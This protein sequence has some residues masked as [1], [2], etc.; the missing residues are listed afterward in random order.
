[1]SESNTDLLAFCVALTSPLQPIYDLVRE[2]DDQK[3][4]TILL[5]PQNVPAQFLPYLAQWVGAILTPGMGE[6]QRRLEI[7]QPTSW[8]RGQDPSIEL[9]TKRELTGEKWVRIRQ[10]TPAPGHTYIRTLL[11][12]TANPDRVK[13][14][15]EEHGV[16][17]WQKLDYEAIAGVSYADIAAGWND[18]EE[19]RAA[20][21]DYAAIR[22]MLPD[23]LPE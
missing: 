14:D 5:D 21:P 23:E 7:E 4:W 13:V 10:R 17:A 20:F 8:K 9:V 12:E 18:Y 15:L 22:D 16:P 11:S 6:E 2:R 19:L 1:M 3:G